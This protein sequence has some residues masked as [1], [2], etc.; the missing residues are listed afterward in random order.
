M[1]KTLIAL[2]TMII[3]PSAAIAGF[4]PGGMGFGPRGPNAEYMARVL[5]LTPEQQEKMKTLWAEQAKKRDEMR[6][7]MQAEMQSKMQAILTKEQFAKMTDLRQMRMAGRGQGMMG[8]G[9]GPNGA[10]CM[11]MGPRGAK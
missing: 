9:M 5:D 3:I 6:A 2:A 4:G 8:Q 10:G 11:G 7:A 1:K